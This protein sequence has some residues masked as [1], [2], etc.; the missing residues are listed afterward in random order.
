MQKYC[1]EC[2]GRGGEDQSGEGINMLDFDTLVRQP[3]D[4]PEQVAFVVPGDLK[5]S[6]IWKEAV[7]SKRM[8]PEFADNIPGDDERKILEQ[9]IKEGGGLPAPKFR[10]DEF[11]SDEEILTAIR[12]DLREIKDTQPDDLPFTRYLVLTQL[13]NNHSIPDDLLPVFRAAVSKM[14][15]SL[16]WKP[17]KVPEFIDKEQT[18]FRIDLRDY[19][20]TD[21]RQWWELVKRYP[22][23]VQYA[24]NRKLENLQQEI[25]E[26]TNSRFSYLRGD[27]FVFAAS[28]LAYDELLGLPNS[29]AELEHRLGVNWVEHFANNEMQRAG[30]VQSNVSRHHRIVERHISDFG[31]YWR[32]YEGD[33]GNEQGNFLL[34]PLG[35]DY[36][37]HPFPEQV[38]S[39]IGGEI[40]FSLPNNLQAYGLY[41]GKDKRL[42]VPAPI[43]VVRDLKESSGTPEV[44]NG[45]S[46]ISCHAQGMRDF[47]DS[48]RDF[49]VVLGEPKRKV[50]SLY[51]PQAEMNKLVDQDRQQFLR[52]VEKATAKFLQVGDNEKKKFE[53]FK[54]EPVSELVQFY[55]S[56]LNGDAVAAELGLKNEEALLSMIQSNRRLQEMGLGPL[57]QTSGVKR[58]LWDRDR[59]DSLFRQILL[60][61]RATIRN[62]D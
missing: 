4:D 13:Y 18:I 24:E 25:D 17:L 52:A 44:V 61:F 45:I 43:T 28:R 15:N 53:D 38:F 19:G 30:T 37:G 50:E 39:Y 16:S 36:T 60:E 22:Y 21:R 34:F 6:K 10:V 11:I 26:L 56:D 12:D 20:W 29:L 32:S 5:K 3:G 42:A 23:G 58:Q 49:A 48:I 59:N 14:I 54:V 7:D 35:P 27:W 41:D 47:K 1:Y 2:H 33:L 55:L 57:L 51:P 46:C 62:V 9:W 31:Y 8:P 40:I